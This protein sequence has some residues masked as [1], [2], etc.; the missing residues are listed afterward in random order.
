MQLTGSWLF[1]QF[2]CSPGQGRFMVTLT[3]WDSKL[4][5]GEGRHGPSFSS[6]HQTKGYQQESTRQGAE[7]TWKLVS[8]LPVRTGRGLHTSNFN[9]LAFSCYICKWGWRN[10][11]QPES[12]M[13][14]NN[15]L[16]ALGLLRELNEIQR[17]DHLLEGLLEGRHQW[18]SLNRK[19]GEKEE[20]GLAASLWCDHIPAPTGL[21]S[22]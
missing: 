15:L 19:V 18:G 2:P 8:F 7:R 10:P 6:F 14:R 3:N 1:G 11:G 4:R 13:E 17:G 16:S 12:G 9:H 20:D 5:S 22:C 21:A